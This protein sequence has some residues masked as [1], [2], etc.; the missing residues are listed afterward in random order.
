MKTNK[1]RNLLESETYIGGHVE[2][3]ESGVFRNDIPVK[4]N[5]DTSAI[6]ELIDDVEETLKFCV[7]VENKRKISE[8][9]NFDEAC[10]KV[11]EQLLI[12]KENPRIEIA[13]LIYHL[14]VAAM[15][16]NI[17]LTN[18]LQPV[19][20]VNEEICAACDYNLPGKTCQRE[21]DW[22]WRGKYFPASKGEIRQIQQQLENESI[23]AKKLKNLT[24]K[25]SEIIRKKQNNT[26]TNNNTNKN[27]RDEETYFTFAELTPSQQNEELLKRV[28]DYCQK[29]YKRQTIEKEENQKSVICQKENGFYVDTVRSFRDRR[30]EYKGKTRMWKER[31]KKAK[32]EVEITECSKNVTLYD[33][34]QLAHKCILNSFYGYVMRRGA[35][36]YSMDMAAITTNIGAN[37]IKDAHNLCQRIGRPIEL[38]TDGIWTMLPSNFPEIIKLKTNDPRPK[39]QIIEVEYPGSMLNLRTHRDWTNHQFQTLEFDEKSGKR[40]YKVKSEC[41]I[42]FEVDGPYLCMVLPASTEENRRLKKRFVFLAVLRLRFFIYPCA[43]LF[44]FCFV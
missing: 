24:W 27:G 14:D 7:E 2:S 16:P 18:R 21:L 37:I 41:S 19:A 22:K 13:P 43:K 32:S 39:K 40:E 42:F 31:L 30:Y 36:W 38:D 33:S 12:L 9:T 6:D 23:D 34:L 28:K 11:K 4:F 44:F 3:F 29:V 1:N 5:I 35:R 15:Y 17:I 8:V 25:Q 20:V 26:N 10:S